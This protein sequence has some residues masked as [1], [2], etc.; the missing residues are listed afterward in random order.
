MEIKF[1][2]T[3]E[4]IELIKL[5]KSTGLCATGGEAKIVVAEG[6]VTVDGELE[7]RKKRKIRSGQTVSFNQHT[8]L[9]K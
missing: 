2:L 6:L 1:K 3:N 7:Y 9:V 5:L 8:I 4:Y